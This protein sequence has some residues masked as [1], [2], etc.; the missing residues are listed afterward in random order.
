MSNF[1]PIPYYKVKDLLMNTGHG[2]K[3]VVQPAINR[4]IWRDYSNTSS[5]KGLVDWNVNKYLNITF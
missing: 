2:W 5:D 3:I 4:S 1:K